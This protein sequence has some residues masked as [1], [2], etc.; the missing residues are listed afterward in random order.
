MFYNEVHMEDLEEV[1]D[2]MTARVDK[3]ATAR[4]DRA[5]RGKIRRPG[6]R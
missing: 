2:Q 6:P 1:Q 4:V 5:A 3:G